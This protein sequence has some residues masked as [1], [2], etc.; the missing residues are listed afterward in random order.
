MFASQQLI[1]G[2]NEDRPL[3]TRGFH[4]RQDSK[5]FQRLFLMLELDAHRINEAR[6]SKMTEQ[7]LLDSFRQ[8]KQMIH[9]PH[10]NVLIVDAGS[11]LFDSMILSRECRL[12]KDRRQ[13][14]AAARDE[15]CAWP[16]VE[17]ASFSEKAYKQP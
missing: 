5:A 3:L 13:K 1:N 16:P 14:S 9:L 6:I 4:G 12:G 7:C 17:L 11:G 15:K 8:P 10:T 2:T